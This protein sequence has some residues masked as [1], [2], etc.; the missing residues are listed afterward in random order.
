MPETP[1]TT[2]E[3]ITD[4]LQS[5]MQNQWVLATNELAYGPFATRD[6]ALSFMRTSFVEVP[7]FLVLPLFP[8][9]PGGT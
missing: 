6:E 4:A 8:P 9:T 2:L 7:D 3:P 1:A 5:V